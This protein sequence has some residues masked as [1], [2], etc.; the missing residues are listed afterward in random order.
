M[1]IPR[2]L[3]KRWHLMGIF[4]FSCV[5]LFSGQSSSAAEAGF[6][7]KASQLM[8]GK[9]YVAAHQE[10]QE[11]LKERP[12]D[13]FLLRNKG[14]CLMESGQHDAAVKVLQR[15]VT[16]D[17]ESISCH[18]FLG[19]ALSYRGS[20]REAVAALESVLALAPDSTYAQQVKT[21]LPQLWELI[22]SAAVI[23]DE[24]RWNLYFSTAADYDDNVSQG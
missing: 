6:Y 22:D 19:Q 14:V 9:D 1:N 12:E 23:R 18:Y 3:T 17:P 11:L 10:I 4:F 21:I 15:A 8:N 5:L 13:I 7:D 20:I 16:I 24:N 2:W